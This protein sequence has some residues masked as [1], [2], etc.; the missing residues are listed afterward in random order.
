MYDNYCTVCNKVTWCNQR[1]LFKWWHNSTLVIARTTMCTCLA[2]EI[3]NSNPFT[4]LKVTCKLKIK[5]LSKTNHS[6]VYIG[7]FKR[8]HYVLFTDL[9]KKTQGIG[10]NVITYVY[11]LR[12]SCDNCGSL[13]VRYTVT[14]EKVFLN[15]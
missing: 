7:D 9:G 3:G 6:D 10:R 11:L 14:P 4:I 13:F 15:Y 2:C 5:W 1:R 12:V 8:N